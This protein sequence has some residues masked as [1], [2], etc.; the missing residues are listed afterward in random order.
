LAFEE[1]EVCD[2]ELAAPTHA[3]HR[4]PRMIRGRHSNAMP[5][6]QAPYAS[7]QASGHGPP[8]DSTPW[9]RRIR[10]AAT[11]ALPALLI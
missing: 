6:S 9:S 3:G 5:C 10:I 1:Y 8:P 4:E 2:S 7:S 11:S